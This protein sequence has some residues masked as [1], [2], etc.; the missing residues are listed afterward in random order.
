MAGLEAFIATDRG[1]DAPLRLETGVVGTWTGAVHSVN[2]LGNTVDNPA[3]ETG[4]SFTAGDVVLLAKYR[5]NYI[6]LFKLTRL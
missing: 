6:V 5:T 3:Y 1:A 4:A 2:V